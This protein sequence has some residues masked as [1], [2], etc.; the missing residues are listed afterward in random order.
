MPILQGV[1]VGAGVN[2]R[3]RLVFLFP[4]FHYFRSSG[5]VAGARKGVVCREQVTTRTFEVMVEGSAERYSLTVPAMGTVVEEDDRQG[6]YTDYQRQLP[7]GAIDLDDLS[8]PVTVSIED[9]DTGEELA[10]YRLEVLDVLA[11]SASSDNVRSPYWSVETDA[12]FVNGQAYSAIVDEVNLGAFSRQILSWLSVGIGADAGVP[13]LMWTPDFEEGI[14]GHLIQVLPENGGSPRI[15]STVERVKRGGEEIFEFPLS[16]EAT[17]GNLSTQRIGGDFTVATDS[18]EVPAEVIEQYALSIE[19]RDRQGV[20]VAY[21]DWDVA[22]QNLANVAVPFEF[23]VSDTL[24]GTFTVTVKGATGEILWQHLYR[25]SDKTVVGAD[26]IHITVP[27]RNPAVLSTDPHGT[28]AS[29]TRLRGRVVQLHDTYN[30]D[31]LTV[32]VTAGGKAGAM[33]TVAAGFTDKD[34]NFSLPYPHGDFARAQAAVSLR[35]DSPVDIAIRD[36]PG[37]T[38]S[39]DFLYILIS[40]DTGTAPVD[41]E[42]PD[43]SHCACKTTP[44]VPRIPDQRELVE[45]GSY[46]QDL[47][48]SCVNLTTPNRTLRETAHRAIVRISDPDVSEYTLVRRTTRE[49]DVDFSLIGGTETTPRNRVVDLANPIRWADAPGNHQNL[50]FYQAV[51]VAAGHILH[52]KSVFKADGYSL[53]DLLYSLPLAPGQKKQMVVLDNAHTLVG[54]DNQQVSQRENLVASIL[55]DRGIVDQISGGL[56]EALRGSS[57]SSTEGVAAGLGAAASVGIIGGSLGVSGGYANAKSS[58]SQNNSRDIT[59]FFNE[60]LRQ[61]IM[62]N[63]DSYRQLNSAVVTT[64]TESQHYAASTDVVANHN[65]CHPM[66]MLYFEVL[67]HYAVFQELVGV[68]EC[69]FVPLLLTNFTVKNVY[70]WK[71]A[72]AR[73][74][75]PVDSNTYLRPLGLFSAKSRHPLVKGFDAIERKATEYIH[76]DYPKGSFADEVITE[77]TG[78]F[79]LRVNIPRPKTRF[80]RIL[81]FPIVKKTVTT[82]GG[83]DVVGTVR[84]TIVDSVVGAV[85]PCAAKGPS[86]KRET[87]SAEILTRQAIFDMF[88]SLDANFETVP[89]ANCIRPNFDNVEIFDKNSLFNLVFEGE[90]TPMDFFAGMSRERELWESYAKILGITLKELFAYFNNNVIADWDRIFNEHVAPMIVEKLLNDQS[91]S[92]IT[93]KPLALD[94]TLEKY[95]GG[96]RLLQCT[97][98]GTTTAKRKD[99]HNLEIHYSSPLTESSYHNA[100][101]GFVTFSVES[102]RLSYTTAFSNGV[103]S[104]RT[105]RD[106]LR[107]AVITPTK[108][109]TPL[110]QDEKRDPHKEDT[111][112]ANQLLDHLNS[113]L[114]HYNRCLWRDL[115]PERRYMLLDG[116]GIKVYDDDGQPGGFRSLA[117]VVKN[118]LIAVVGNSLVFPVAA[119]CRV[120]NSYIMQSHERDERS[121]TDALFNH[122]RPLTPPAPYRVSVPNRGVFLEAVMGNCDACEPVKPNS[123]Q[124]WDLF[125]TEEPTSI[126]PIVTPV[127]TVTD[128]KAVFRDLAQPIVNIQN[129]PAAPAPAS[130][131]AG[132]SE[133]LG[134]SSTFTDI[135]GLAGTQ[136]NA[137]QTYLS[138]QQTVRTMAEIAKGLAT[139]EHNTKNS[140]KIVTAVNEAKKAGAIDSDTQSELIRKHLQNQIDGGDSERASALQE[141]HEAQPS[142]TQAAISAVGRADSVDASRTGGDGTQETISIKQ[143]S[144]TPLFPETGVGLAQRLYDDEQARRDKLTAKDL[145]DFQPKSENTLISYAL[146]YPAPSGTT[147]VNWKRPGLDHYGTILKGLKIG[148][149]RTK[150]PTTAMQYNK[151]RSVRGVILHETTGWNKVGAG[152]AEDY[153]FSVHF[154]VAPSGTIYQHND[155]G[156]ILEHAGSKNGSSANL[157]TVGIEV[158]GLSVFNVG[159]KTPAKPT[160]T[161][162]TLHS[163]QTLAELGEK[164]SEYQERIPAAWIDGTTNTF[165]YALP[166]AAQMEGVAN[167][168]RWLCGSTD[169]VPRALYLDIGEDWIWRPVFR[170]EIGGSIRELFMLSHNPAWMQPGQD[171]FEGILAHANMNEMRKDGGVLVLYCWLR[172]RVGL[173]AAEAYKLTRELISDPGLVRT[174]VPYSSFTVTAVDISGKIPGRGIPV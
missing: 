36:R 68:E 69:V 136:A 109:P 22:V 40:E 114:E 107:D 25:A 5:A 29:E 80:D 32:V 91:N 155:I 94:F 21:H 9:A 82:Q 72:L 158:T 6:L 8:F 50:S 38:I 106:D 92:R 143:V 35:P 45:S 117:S 64:A 34:G 152:V 90:T 46:S 168:V 61:S 52:Y 87:Q 135:T 163:E 11:G 2:Q 93:V 95:T 169:R 31:R 37:R 75:K 113:N 15:R 47:G 88:M 19:Y 108:I 49:D 119:G 167:L 172:L 58:A 57:A 130:G 7:S 165:L 53:G 102:I 164:T 41:D 104:S 101:F 138:N 128:W 105:I 140:E 89:P 118:E 42:H 147:V 74:L 100:F 48:G 23:R 26:N 71:D 133:L 60:Q 33:R 12:Y 120:S 56:T 65:H 83:V 141:H 121:I 86:I 139:Q 134:K 66:T 10:R 144:D 159:S 125:T 84:D 161:A 115:D 79:T 81:S 28:V 76:V 110:S 97:V 13:V 27:L 174:K 146:E 85:V 116:F 4:V 173:S 99:I 150:N 171:D 77:V 98:R 78:T 16:V 137:E 170:A 63:A 148:G 17:G 129:A 126:N 111:Y 162:G 59:Q 112:I 1:I 103:L 14:T 132:V 153:A 124:D 154:S 156:Q 160:G 73:N 149:S 44:T 96:E 18:T 62:Q 30:L 39:D 54:T 131:L 145:R 122:Y 20:H 3:Y 166:A 127:P 70:K 67:R 55:N 24:V 51:S 123:S 157:T 43:H 142:L 151:R